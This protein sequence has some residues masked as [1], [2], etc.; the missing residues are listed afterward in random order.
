MTRLLNTPIIGRSAA[1]VAS[2]CSDMLAGLSKN[3]ILRMPPDFCAKAA[4]PA[5]RASSSEP[6]ITNPRTCRFMNLPS[7]AAG[8]F[9]EPHVFEAP[10]VVDVVDHDRQP[11]D[12]GLAAGC[13][14]RIEDH[15]P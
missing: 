6:A 5:T 13:T 2:S 12:F 4:S 3:E 9:V 15:R 10:A 8:L 7:S 11:P 14:A 1:P